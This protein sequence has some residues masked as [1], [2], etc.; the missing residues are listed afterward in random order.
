MRQIRFLAAFAGMLVGALIHVESA[1]AGDVYKYVDE[2]GI[3]LYTDKPMPGAVLVSSG[4]QRPPEVAQR[5]QAAA[6]AT[7]ATQL[8]ASNQRIAEAQTNQ[9]AAETVAKDLEAT[10]LERCKKARTSYESTIN[11]QRIYREKEGGQ[12]EYLTEAEL[13]QTRVD[14]RKAVDAICGPQG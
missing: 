9:R 14:A 12:R 7:T 3:T 2:R 8:T 11:S 1:Q 4:A 6:R 10:R 5:T 13:A